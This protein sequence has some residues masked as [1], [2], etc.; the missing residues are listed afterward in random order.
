MTS[1]G[2]ASSSGT[3]QPRTQSCI[4]PARIRTTGT[5][6]SSSAVC[7]TGRS[8]GLPMEARGRQN[9]IRHWRGGSDGQNV[10]P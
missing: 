2:S 8:S 7:G 3:R 6:S 10:V 9:A 5:F 4:S 1:T